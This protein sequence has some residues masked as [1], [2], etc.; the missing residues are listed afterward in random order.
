MITIR[1]MEINDIDVVIN[2]EH[3]GYSFPWSR[4]LFEQ[5]IHSNKYAAVIEYKNKICGYAVLSYVVGE[6]ELLNI[7]VDPKE[8]GQG[9]AQTLLKHLMDEAKK[10][11]NHEMFL[12]VRPSN[13]AAIHIYQKHGFNEIGRRKDYYPT[14]G[15][16]EDALLMAAVL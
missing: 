13:D 12:E 7:C 10:A 9:L 5:A 4:S 3:Q 16:R 11:E 8:R 6:A 14:K 2:I 15:G 1:S